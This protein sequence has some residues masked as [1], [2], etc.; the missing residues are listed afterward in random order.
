M[1]RLGGNGDSK[2][3]CFL[4]DLFVSFVSSF[5][6]FYVF[7]HD[8]FIYF[9]FFMCFNVSLCRNSFRVFLQHLCVW[10][11]TTLCKRYVDVELSV[12]VD[13]S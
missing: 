7:V 8:W 9:D 10:P 12:S 1:G 3:G 13:R 4:V 6:I 5:L 11:L 2:D